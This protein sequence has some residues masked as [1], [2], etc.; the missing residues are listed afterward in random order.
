MKRPKTFVGVMRFPRGSLPSSLDDRRWVQ[1]SELSSGI[2]DAFSLRL[3]LLDIPSGDAGSSVSESP[4]ELTVHFGWQRN[5]LH[6]AVRDDGSPPPA[7]RPEA[8]GEFRSAM[9]LGRQ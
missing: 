6:I 7:I 4:A 3:N 2:G 9:L 1:P 5:Q 8:W